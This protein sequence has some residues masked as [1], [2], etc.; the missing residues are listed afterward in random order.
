M[1]TRVINFI[2]HV[3]HLNTHVTFLNTRIIYLNIRIT[4]L[5]I[6]IL[7]FNS[8]LIYLNNRISHFK[9]HVIHEMVCITTAALLYFLTVFVKSIAPYFQ[10]W[11]RSKQREQNHPTPST[12]NMQK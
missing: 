10:L 1:N 6:H 8:H 11:K 9:S 12:P 7:Y 3:T 2:S 5:N 4:H